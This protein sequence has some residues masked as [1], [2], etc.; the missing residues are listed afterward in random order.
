MHCK[1]IDGGDYSGKNGPNIATGV[2][3][4]SDKACLQNRISENETSQQE[5]YLA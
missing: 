2:D 3:R 1:N 5:T 4:Y